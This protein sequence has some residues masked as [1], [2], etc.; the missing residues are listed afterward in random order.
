MHKRVVAAILGLGLVVAGPS[1]ADHPNPIQV[2]FV[3]PGFAEPGFWRS[4]TDV[5]ETAGQQLGMVVDVSFGDREWPKMRDNAQAAIQQATQIDYLIL[6][7]EHQQAADLVEAANSRQIATLFLLNSLTAEQEASVGRPRRELR[8]W[9]GSLTPDNAKAGYEMAAAVIE[10]ARRLKPGQGK[11]ELISL[12]GDFATPASI[13]RL[14]GLDAAL[15]SNEDVEE[16]RRL[17]VNWSYDKAYQRIDTWLDT[18]QSFDAVWAANDPIALGAMAAAEQHGLTAGKDYAIAGLNW[19]APALEAVQSGQMT[20]THGG[21]FLAGA[22]AMV[23]LH[24]LHHGID[25]G[26]ADPHL[27]FPMAAI[28]AT[29]SPV[30]FDVL[31]S[32]AWSRIDFKAFSQFHNPDPKGYDFSVQAIQSA[33]TAE[34]L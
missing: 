27:H 4:V 15:S 6:V 26:A 30:L 18:G 16:L 14:K 7:N 5:M 11:I 13:D 23:L 9:L 3:N 19:S 1:L 31:S 33:I 25:F 17:T 2:K 34:P 32:E 29:V 22:W 21:H 12:A 20:L 24:D 10:T 8:F 28:D